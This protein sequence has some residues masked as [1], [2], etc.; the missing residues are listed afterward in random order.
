[1]DEIDR[2]TEHLVNG[3]ANSKSEYKGVVGEISGLRKSLI[4]CEEVNKEFD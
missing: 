2:L 4:L 1:M 3:G